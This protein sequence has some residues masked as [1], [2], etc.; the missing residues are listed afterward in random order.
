VIEHTL[1]WNAV[2]A[3]VTA[4]VRKLAD[5]SRGSVMTPF[6]ARVAEL[7][8]ADPGTPPA[9]PRYRTRLSA[10]AA[11]NRGA[12]RHIAVR[13]LAEQLVCEANAVLADCADHLALA[14]EAGTAELA[15]TVYYRNRAV[16]FT[17]RF[18][19]GTA[20][21]QLAGDGVP[22]GPPRELASAE[23]IA[24]LLATLLVRAGLPHHEVVT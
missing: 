17:T 19:D 20:F 10:A 2:N 5:E 12:D 8:G 9:P 24:D 1:R 15:F 22:A 7:I 18:A 23:D 6:M 16:R 11:V 13:A 4:A 14:D 3:T 21:G